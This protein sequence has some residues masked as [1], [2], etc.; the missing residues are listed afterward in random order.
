MKKL[1]APAVLL[2]GCTRPEVEDIFFDPSMPPPIV[3]QVAPPSGEPDAGLEDAAPTPVSQIDVVPCLDERPS[4]EGS[5]YISHWAD[6]EYP[7]K[8]MLDLANLKAIVTK[9]VDE[10]WAKPSFTGYETAAPPLIGNGKATF[11]C[12]C[13]KNQ[14]DGDLVCPTGPAILEVTF[15]LPR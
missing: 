7:G 1:I 2:F 5:Q 12:G 3:L 15:V 4:P 10:P 14:P 11:N 9:R 8:T 6:I 13:S